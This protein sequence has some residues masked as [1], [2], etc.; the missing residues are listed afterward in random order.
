MY[1]RDCALHLKEFPILLYY[2]YY[3]YNKLDPGCFIHCVSGN[4]ECTRCCTLGNDYIVSNWR[5]RLGQSWLASHLLSCSALYSIFTVLL[6]QENR[7]NEECDGGRRWWDWCWNQSGA[8][9][10]AESKRE[11]GKCPVLTCVTTGAACG[12]RADGRSGSFGSGRRS[13]GC[14][15]SVN[16]SRI[17]PFS[18][19]V[20]AC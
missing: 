4:A 20:C 2:Y 19:V 11:R 10:R 17:R 3:Y 14:V 6:G 7:K 15:K 16:P 18:G 9:R 8:S 1:F 5:T 13:S 12:G